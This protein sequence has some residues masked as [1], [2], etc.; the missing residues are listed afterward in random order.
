MKNWFDYH[1]VWQALPIVSE[2]LPVTLTIFIYSTV[3]GALLGLMLAVI[4]TYRIFILNTATVIFVSYARGTPVLVQLILIY[5]LLPTI[6]A[7][8]G[9]DI[10]KTPELYFVIVAIGLYLSANFCEIFR[11]ALNNVERSQIEAAYSI[12][13][14]EHQ[15]FSRVMMPQAMMLAIPDMGN[16]FLLSLKSTSLAFTVGIMDIMG[17]GI[18]LSAQTMRSFE[19]FVAI[20][21]IYFLLCLFMENIFKVIEKKFTLNK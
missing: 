5:Y 19:V 2:Y 6:L 4:R 21:I 20:S 3:M 18:T 14:K 15:V 10:N 12:G 17:R 1:L 11:S 7:R 16:I 9:I 13:M 8:I